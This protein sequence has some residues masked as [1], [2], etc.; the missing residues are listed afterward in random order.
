LKVSRYVVGKL[1]PQ[2][3]PNPADVV[4]PPVTAG[5]TAKSKEALTDEYQ[6]KVRA[7]RGNKTEIVK[8]R[9]QYRKEGVDVYNVDFS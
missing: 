2:K 3:P 4:Q 8:L 6:T 5:A 9:E 1:A 7:A